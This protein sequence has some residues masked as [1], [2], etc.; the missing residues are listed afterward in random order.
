MLS[1][2]QILPGAFAF[3]FSSS[4]LSAFLGEYILMLKYASVYIPW[5]YSLREGF[6]FFSSSAL[7][8][9]HFRI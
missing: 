6:L 1:H 9:T 3:Y 2:L 8:V 5:H 7:G 4:S